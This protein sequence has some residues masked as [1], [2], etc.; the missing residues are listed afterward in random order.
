MWK[1]FRGFKRPL[2]MMSW[3]GSSTTW[4]CLIWCPLGRKRCTPLCCLL[5]L[6]GGGKRREGECYLISLNITLHRVQL[7][8]KKS[9]KETSWSWTRERTFKRKG[10]RKRI[11]SVPCSLICKKMFSVMK[12]CGYFCWWEQLP[13]FLLVILRPLTCV[14]TT[15]K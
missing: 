5:W 1:R 6:L 13:R 14:R 7:H 11:K 2:N 3:T 9:R 8:H 4:D 12:D 15:N 10:L